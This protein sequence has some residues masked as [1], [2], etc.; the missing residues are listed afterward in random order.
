M[1]SRK[2]DFTLLDHT[3]D[4]GMTVRGHDPK[5]LFEG[6]ARSMMQIM[7]NGRS[8]ESTRTR[9][10]SVVG[11][12]PSDLMVRWLGEI[13]YFF[14][15]E[16]EVVDDVQIN[17]IS[18]FHLEATLG[19]VPFDPGLHDILCEVKAVTY[20]QIEVAKKTHQWEATIIFDI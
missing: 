17:S 1:K 8:P 10:L 16:R 2:P 20:H 3:A 7:V 9:K 14:N 13:L 18:D 4:L 6:A 12:D 11:E 19:V 5:D 15:G